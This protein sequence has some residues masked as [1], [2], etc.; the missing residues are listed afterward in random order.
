MWVV[1]VFLFNQKTAYEM[2]ISDWSSDVCSSDLPGVGRERRDL[3]DGPCH[4]DP[5]RGGVGGERA[6]V[7]ARALAEPVEVRV[8]PDERGQDDV[9]HDFATVVV[10][11]AKPERHVVERMIGMPFEEQQRL[12]AAEDMRQREGAARHERGDGERRRQIG[13]AHVWTPV[14]NAHL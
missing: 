7:M 1:S 12:R 8:E 14:P 3:L 13:S 2:S 9:G 5:P 4:A 6:V 11:L 10:R